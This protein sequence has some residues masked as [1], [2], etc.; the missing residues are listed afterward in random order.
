MMWLPP[1]FNRFDMGDNHQGRHQ[2][3][4]VRTTPTLQC[5]AYSCLI[6]SSRRSPAVSSALRRT[7]KEGAQLHLRRLQTSSPSAAAAHR[8]SLRSRPE[9]AMRGG[10]RA[11]SL[12][13]AAPRRHHRRSRRRPSSLVLLLLRSP[14]LLRRPWP[15]RRHCHPPAKP[16]PLPPQAAAV[17]AA[18]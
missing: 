10:C 2:P 4:P 11:F 14:L 13:P 17:L 9:T 5:C 8:A 12:L 15:R 7:G 1:S 6:S 3:R 16:K 18:A